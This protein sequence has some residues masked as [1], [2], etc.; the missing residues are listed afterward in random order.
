MSERRN[1][2]TQLL[3][4]KL[5][6]LPDHEFTA[7]DQDLRE[8]MFKYAKPDQLT[9]MEQVQR[10]LWRTQMQ[11][12]MPLDMQDFRERNRDMPTVKAPEYVMPMKKN[13][14]LMTPD[15]RM[16]GNKD[17]PLLQLASPNTTLQYE[18]PRDWPPPPQP[19]PEVGA[20]PEPAPDSIWP[21]LEQP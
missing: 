10:Q 18:A 7:D 14:P 5:G 16:M 21:P 15:L 19:S 20:Q 11:N 3:M 4:E 6:L 13:D 8:K 12:Q 17:Y 1:A 2:I 9:T